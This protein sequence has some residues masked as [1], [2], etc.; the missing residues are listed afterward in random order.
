[1]KRKGVFKAIFKAALVGG[2]Q[3][4]PFGNVLVKIG[5]ALPVKKD[6]LTEDEENLIKKVSLFVSI[7]V[8]IACVSAIFYSFYKGDITVNQLLELINGTP[9]TS[10]N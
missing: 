9:Q 2:L 8:E 3:S 6:V 1:M 7:A 4:L 5:E 10:N